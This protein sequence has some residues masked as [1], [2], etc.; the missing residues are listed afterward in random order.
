MMN[1]LLVLSLMIL[2]SC[3]SSYNQKKS[4]GNKSPIDSAKSSL[5]ENE[6]L[7]ILVSNSLPEKIESQSKPTYQDFHQVTIPFDLDT[8][9]PHDYDPRLYGYIIRGFEVDVN[10]RF[11][12]MGGVDP[13]VIACFEEEKE[14]WRKSYDQFRPA[15]IH[16]YRDTLFFFDKWP[17]RNTIFWLD[18]KDGI[19]LKTFK[20]ITETRSMIP[21]F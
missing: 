10:G 5:N 7:T 6:T 3:E 8:G 14:V 16:S 4:F 19:I 1:H 2:F 20:S 21:I 17:D 9:V 13:T 12:F 11:Y 15:H 18:Q